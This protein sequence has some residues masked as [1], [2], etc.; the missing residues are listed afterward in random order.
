MFDIYVKRTEGKFTKVF[1]KSDK[2]D[3]D[4][5]ASYEKK[6]L[7]YFYVINE[8]YQQYGLYVEKLGRDLSD[9][10]LKLSAN[11]TSSL[12]RE[13]VNFTMREIVLNNNISEKTVNN[14]SNVI[15]SCVSSLER[16]PKSLMRLVSLMSNQHYLFRHSINVSIFSVLLAKESGVTSESNLNL[17]G[18]G[19]FLHDIGISQLTF[20]PE[21]KEQLSPEERKE[22]W[23]HP[24]MG[25]RM[26]DGIKSIRT[27]V[28]DIIMQHHEQ[29]NGHGYPNGLREGEIYPP[30]KI[31]SIADT[32]AS[33]IT[34]RSYRDAFT[35]QDA[36]LSMKSDVGKF[37]KHLLKTFSQLFIKS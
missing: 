36:I 33:M 16:N 25:K 9:S 29:P 11:E 22:M 10:K 6:G 34:K 15:K 12:L 31:V 4:R 27:E 26:L 21:E 8:D 37:D 24:E 35:V 5:V 14:A 3:W 32:F 20:N 23:R 2:I 19:A 18:L 1:N 30:A 13:M 28:I 17:I 7:Q